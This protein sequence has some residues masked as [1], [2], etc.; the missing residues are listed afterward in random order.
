MTLPDGWELATVAARVLMLAAMAGVCGSSLMLWLLTRASLPL[1]ALLAYSRAS[2]AVGL[3]AA[4]VWLL[5]QAGG[6]NQSG[7]SGMFDMS[8]VSLLLQS[9]L[10][11]VTGLRMAA[12]VLVLLATGGL[13][14]GHSR[15]M[16]LVVA[17]LLVCC[18]VVLTGHISTLSLT[19]RA[20]LLVHVLGALSWVGSLYVL[21]H[22]CGTTQ[23]PAL[24]ALMQSFGRVAV[25]IVGVLL[26]AGLLLAV[27][28]LQAPSELWTTPYG[29]TLLG[30]VLLVGALL[31]LAALNKLWWVPQLLQTGA[32][33]LQRS[34]RIE[35]ALALLVLASTAW[36]TT[37]T[38]PTA[39]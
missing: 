28:L 3:L 26:P 29:A 30:K 5:L 39:M 24:Q 18:S 2:A 6:I 35:T 36:L 22:A 15:Q 9:T 13:Q 7:L 17:A 10:G 14:A 12:C 32:V 4:P 21:Q 38:G 8:M 25:V 34:I 20:I 1:Q 16:G 37:V 31:L 11:W 19:V 23:L 27:Q 33:S